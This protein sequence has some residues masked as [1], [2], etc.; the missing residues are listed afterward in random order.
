[1]VQTFNV[2][3]VD[4]NLNLNLNKYVLFYKNVYNALNRENT[5]TIRLKNQVLWLRNPDSFCK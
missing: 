2:I 5:S 3:K 1:M 4:I